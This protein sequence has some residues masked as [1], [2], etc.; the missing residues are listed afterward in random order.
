MAYLPYM[1][2]PAANL[3]LDWTA[4]QE[5]ALLDAALAVLAEH[6]AWDV[7]LV[8]KAGQRLGM[9]QA[10]VELVLPNGPRDLSV[11]LARRHDTATLS[12]LSHLDPSALKVRARIRA[13]VLARVE[14]AM[15]DEAAV[16]HSLG[17]LLLP[18]NTKTL[19]HLLWGA[20]DQIWHW[21]GDTATDLNHYSKRTLLSGVIA[22][23]L[24]VRLRQG[25]EAAEQTLDRAIDAVMQFE[26][27]KSRFSL[28]P[29]LLAEKAVRGM[30]RVRYGV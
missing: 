14:S 30:A 2:S 17:T 10:L 5:Q 29:L 19:A 21:A 27:L 26:M 20:A 9:S 28:D 4:A 15:V 18:H 22:A 3:D 1:S 13:G 7:D 16:R 12:R 25:Q 24:S 8:R 11:L 6:G 23:T